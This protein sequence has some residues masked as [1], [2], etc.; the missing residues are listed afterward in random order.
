MC[1]KKKLGGGNV[2]QIKIKQKRPMVAMLKLPSFSMLS[3]K[4]QS[5]CKLAKYFVLWCSFLHFPYFKALKKQVVI[6]SLN[7]VYEL[8]TPFKFKTLRDNY[9]KV[10][11]IIMQFSLEIK[12]KI[13]GVGSM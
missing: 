3:T 7:R 2:F 10:Q 13:L 6:L 9:K 5:L 1:F 4:E 8:N 11:W 12:K